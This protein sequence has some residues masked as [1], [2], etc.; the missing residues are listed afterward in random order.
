MQEH[1]PNADVPVVREADDERPIPSAWR[2]VL[3]DI[4]GAFAAHDYRLERGIPGVAPVS[5]ATATQIRE[6]IEDY[7]DALTGLPDAAWETSACIWTGD[8]WDALVDLWT[9]NEGASDLA[10]QVRVV[11]TDGEFVF[12]VHMVYVP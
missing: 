1:D 12:E 2:P 10:L 11:E 9:E 4:V 5:H 7:G 3:S 6:A 8:H